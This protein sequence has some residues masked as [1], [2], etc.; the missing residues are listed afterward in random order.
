MLNRS[1]GERYLVREFLGEGAHGTVYRAYDHVRKGEVALKLFKEGFMDV[2][3]A[4][5]ARH[6]EVSEGS[7]VLPLLEVHPEFAEG[8]VTVM[9]LMDGTLA[10]LDTVFASKAIHYTRRLLTGLEYC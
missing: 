4:E 2:Q 9:K 1:V 5:A 7:A 6:F 3:T 8:Q 10:D